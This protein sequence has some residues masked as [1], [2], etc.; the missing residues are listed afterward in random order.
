MDQIQSSH[1]FDRRIFRQA[2][3]SRFTLGADEPA[4]DG[5]SS[6]VTVRLAKLDEDV[7]KRGI[8]QPC[9]LVGLVVGR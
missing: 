2:A 7:A 9:G 8:V 6:R 3:D 4:A 1:S 5:G